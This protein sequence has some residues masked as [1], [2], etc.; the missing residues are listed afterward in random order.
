MGLKA[1]NL[2]KEL[3][4]A[5]HCLGQDVRED[6]QF[7][8][9]ADGRVTLTKTRTEAGTRWIVHETTAPGVFNFECDGAGENRF[10]DGVTQACGVRLAPDVQ[11]HSG[12]AWK[13]I[14]L[15]DPDMGGFDHVLLQTQG[16]VGNVF[17]NQ[18]PHGF[19]NGR[20]VEGTLE[21]VAQL[22]EGMSGT[23][24]EMIVWEAS[25]GEGGGTPDPGTLPHPI[26]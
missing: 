14:D 16:K 2:R 26:Q 18:C 1:D 11:F 9:G 12:T 10:L 22:L 23:H 19:L 20:T 4:I 7:L 5:F 24:W 3:G 25:V 8:K 21:L 17:L 13:V 6:H 15:P